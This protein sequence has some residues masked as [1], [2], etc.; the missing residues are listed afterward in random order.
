M[1]RDM[2]PVFII[3]NTYEY[4]S[5]SR[6]YSLAGSSLSINMNISKFYRL[7]IVINKYKYL[8]ILKPVRMKCFETEPLNPSCTLTI[9]PD[10]LRLQCILPSQ[11]RTTDHW[12]KISQ[13]YN[14]P[15]RHLRSFSLHQNKP[16]HASP[17]L[18][19]TELVSFRAINS[20]QQTAG[21]KFP[22]P[23]IDFTTPLGKF[24][25]M[26]PTKSRGLRVNANQHT[27]IANVFFYPIHDI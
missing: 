24:V 11:H 25:V 2:T 14:V 15:H 17:R 10:L 18:R 1:F 27:A 23:A 12:Q 8:K 21:R 4:M 7:V 3:I 22:N 20:G 9:R 6:F 5:V 16:D 26:R 13:P 19:P